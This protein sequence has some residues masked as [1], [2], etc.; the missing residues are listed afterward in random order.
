MKV[1]ARMRDNC[2]NMYGFII[3]KLS[4]ES[5]DELRHQKEYE[6]IN[7]KVNLL[8]LWRLI[9]R[10]HQTTII[11]KCST[12]M[13]PAANEA[14]AKCMQ[15]GFE[16]IMA[17]RE[18]FEGTSNANKEQGNVEKSEEDRAMDFLHSLDMQR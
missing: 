10:I 8:E 1:I 11:S 15:G 5:K 17:F 4:T 16:Y 9:C 7:S 3:S 6:K 2:T 13:K 12:I 18:I 14:Y